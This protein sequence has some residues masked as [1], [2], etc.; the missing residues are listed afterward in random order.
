MRAC[1]LLLF[2]CA[3]A[4]LAED[5]A[6]ITNEWQNADAALRHVFAGGS[7]YGKAYAAYGGL[8]RAF[9]DVVVA[10]EP[11]ESW[12]GAAVV[13]IGCGAAWLGV[14]ALSSGARSY[15]GVDAS[16]ASLVAARA[17]LNGAGFVEGA[18]YDLRSAEAARAAGYRGSDIVV[19]LKVMQHF[20][21][22]AYAA[23]WLRS[24]AEAGAGRVVVS[25]A[26]ATS[27]GVECLPAWTGGRAFNGARCFFTASYLGAALRP[28]G[29]DLA[30]S[31]TAGDPVTH[32]GGRPWVNVY[33]GFHLADGGL[34]RP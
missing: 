32:R 11:A 23:A 6:L 22:V 25:F 28:F 15:V 9:E 4:D 7:A 5:E 24:V 29:Y 1:L 20:P 31:T 13:D 34:R 27:G 26:E 19:A 17:T 2:S 12:R 10:S 3:A 21:S 14:W 16:A 8:V 30:W 33:A 18:L